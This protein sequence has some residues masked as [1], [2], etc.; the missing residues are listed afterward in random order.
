MILNR[1]IICFLLVLLMVT[2]TYGCVKKNNPINDNNEVEIIEV[3][4]LNVE[5]ISNNIVDKLD[6]KDYEISDKVPGNPGVLQQH[7]VFQKKSGFYLSFF[8]EYVEDNSGNFVL[9]AFDKD[10]LLVWQRKWMEIEISE[11][12]MGTEPTVEEEIVYIGVSGNVYALNLENG[13]IVWETTKT[14]STTSPLI[15]EDAVYISDFESALLTSINKNSGVVNWSLSNNSNLLWP[16]KTWIWKNSVIVAC[17]TLIPGQLRYVTIG[18]NGDI[19]DYRDYARYEEP[20]QFFF[21]EASTNPELETTK[22]SPSNVFDGDVRT[23]W[24]IQESVK[25]EWLRFSADNEKI[26]KIINVYNGNQENY[27]KFKN[28]GKAKSI[29][30]DFSNGDYL[31]YNFKNDKLMNIEKIILSKL[32]VAYKM[33]ITFLDSTSSDICISELVI[34]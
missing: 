20:I 16:V 3:E 11:L 22:Y 32:V 4:E 26:I 19:I 17:E 25:G 34:N 31:I 9:E 23:A 14:G 21:T 29:R 28:N 13:D 2:M 18:L 10:G 27:E 33:K 1:I 15:F 12:P 24:M 6:N 7:V 8:E 5:E 30:I